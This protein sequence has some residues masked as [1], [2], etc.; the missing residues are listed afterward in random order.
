M[1]WNE[2]GDE[3]KPLR[4]LCK[5]IRPYLSHSLSLSLC[6]LC[7]YSFLFMHTHTHRTHDKKSVLLSQKK[8]WFFIVLKNVITNSREKNAKKFFLVLF[9][10]GLLFLRARWKKK[11]SFSSAFSICVCAPGLAKKNLFGD[12]MNAPLSSLY[13]NHRHDGSLFFDSGSAREQSRFCKQG[14]INE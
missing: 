9:Q 10:K 1:K 14:T 7:S 3:K 12:E 8:E 2:E 4:V 5:S 6:F 11:I 13:T